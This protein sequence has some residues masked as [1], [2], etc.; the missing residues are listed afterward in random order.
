MYRNQPSVPWVKL[1]PSLAGMRCLRAGS[2]VRVCRGCLGG[3]W[4]LLS[5]ARVEVATRGAETETVDQSQVMPEL[6]V[7]RD[8]AGSLL[9]E[10]GLSNREVDLEEGRAPPLASLSSQSLC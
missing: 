6:G 3:V 8:P 5:E 10:A 2:G 1:H 9:E 7:R 4:D